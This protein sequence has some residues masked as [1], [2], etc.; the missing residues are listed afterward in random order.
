MRKPAVA[1]AATVA[2]PG[3]DVEVVFGDGRFGGVVDDGHAFGEGFADGGCAADHE[4]QE[5]IAEL[6]P[7]NLADV[8][9]QRKRGVELVEEI[10]ELEG[11][12]VGVDD[13]VEE[14]LDA[15]E[16]DDGVHVGRDRDEDGGAETGHAANDPAGADGEVEQN[17]V[18]SAAACSDLLDECVLGCLV[19]GFLLDVVADEVDGGVGAAAGR[20]EGAN[21]SLP[22]LAGAEVEREQAM[23]GGVGEE[24]LFTEG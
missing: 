15:L 10:E 17:A 7:E 12:T 11:A 2:E 3:C 16:A 1:G 9:V 22:E 13:A 6:P 23:G 8:E 5:A 18:R 20:R 24:D 21:G 19:P 4:G 14:L